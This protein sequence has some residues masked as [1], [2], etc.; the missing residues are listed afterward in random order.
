MK[1]KYETTLKETYANLTPWQ[2]VQVARHPQRPY[3]L[4]YIG[5]IMDD[6]IEISG[7]RLFG[8]DKAI[9]IGFARLGEHKV[10]IVGHQKGRGTKENVYRHFGSAHPEGYRKALRA[11]DGY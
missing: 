2:R 6:F 3:T 11:S 5:L 9:V 4:D 8:D 7:D 1:K 10:M